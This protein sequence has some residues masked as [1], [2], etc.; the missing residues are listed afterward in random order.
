MRTATPASAFMEP[1]RPRDLQIRFITVGGSYVDVTGPSRHSDR[2]CWHW[3]GCGDSSD[4]PE[5]D[6]L[7][8]TRRDANDHAAACRAIPL[9]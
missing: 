6:W 5:Q 1:A 9:T 7:F 4:S 2:S 3:H 8:R